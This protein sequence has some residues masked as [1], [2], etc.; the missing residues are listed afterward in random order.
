MIFHWTD[1]SPKLIMDIDG[2]N[3]LVVCVYLDFNLVHDR[4]LLEFGPFV[5]YINKSLSFSS[6]PSVTGCWRW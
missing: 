4:I 5:L 3:L 1:L 6:L 2:K